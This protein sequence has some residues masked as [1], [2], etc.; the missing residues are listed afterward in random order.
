MAL[1]A[2]RGLT[3]ATG[4]GFSPSKSVLSVFGMESE[5][6]REFG[7]GGDSGRVCKMYVE[8]VCVYIEHVEWLAHACMHEAKAKP[9]PSGRMR[10][11]ESE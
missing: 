6:D 11:A 3:V 5:S 4:G 1:I 10:A 7:R 9:N 2:S 8:H